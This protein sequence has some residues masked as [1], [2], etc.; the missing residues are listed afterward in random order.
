MKEEDIEFV[1]NI[2][3]GIV[4]FRHINKDEIEIVHFVGFHKKPTE[5]DIKEITKE[6][7][8]DPEFEATFGQIN[9]TVFLM[10]ATPEMVKFHKEIDFEYHHIHER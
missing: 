1:K 3:Y 8:D 4:A 9:K 5:I 2:N 6:L 7:N 10:E